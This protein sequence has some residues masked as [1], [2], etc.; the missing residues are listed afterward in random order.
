MDGGT[1]AAHD[2]PRSPR[3]GHIGH[4]KRCEIPDSDGAR[5]PEKVVVGPFQ[6]EPQKR[7]LDARPRR[8]RH[9]YGPGV[10]GKSL[11]SPG[12]GGGRHRGEDEAGFGGERP[13]PARHLRLRHRYRRRPGRGWRRESRKAEKRGRVRLPMRRR[14]AAGELGQNGA[15]SPEQRGRQARQQGALPDRGDQD[16]V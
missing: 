9:R 10:L 13:R 16:V 5:G 4:D 15:P 6:E 14:P 7:S 3:A 12:S 11:G 2:S 1:Q 8:R